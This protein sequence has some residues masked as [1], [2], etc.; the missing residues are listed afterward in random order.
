MPTLARP[1]CSALFS[2]V[3]ALF[4]GSLTAIAVLVTSVD[5]ARADPGV[6]YVDTDAP[7]PTH[8]GLSWTTAFTSV[9]DALGAATYDDQIW[10]AEGVYFPDE[11][12]GQTN[13]DRVSTFT[14]RPGVALCGGF[15]GGEVSLTE[16]DWTVNVTVLSGDIDGDD[17]TDDQGVVTDTANIKNNNAY[18]VVTGVA[19][20][21]TA[22]LDGF[23]ITAGSADGHPADKLGGGILNDN[24]SSPTLTNL[25]FSGNR[26]FSAGGGIYCGD[27]SSPTLSNAS[28]TSNSAT[29]SGGGMYNSSYSSPR[30]TNVT[31]EGNS[32]AT[33][34]ESGAGM[35]N[36]YYSSP[37]LINVV[38]KGN[39]TSPA[40]AAA[41]MSNRYGSSPMLA[42][43][44]FSGNRGGTVGAMENKLSSNPTLVNCVLWGNEGSDR[45]TIRNSGGSSPTISYSDV[46]G[47]GG[48]DNW[49]AAPWAPTAGTTSTPTRCSSIPSPG[50]PRPRPQATTACGPAPRPST[51][52]TISPSP[53]PPTSTA[54]HASRT[55]TGTA[56]KWWICGR[57]RQG[58]PSAASRCGAANALRSPSGQG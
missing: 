58:S 19:L 16:R 48:S 53:S 55:A 38:F 11:G 35:V 3:S 32:S 8:N 21:E 18:H 43:V 10:V 12:A 47:S 28:L 27:H 45:P 13:D 2:V 6:I 31:F 24:H 23:T 54:S 14:L 57:M 7:G 4:L 29:D 52:G 22:R 25:V 33:V 40:G 5:T 41:A 30:L 44:T 42:S 17:D 1:T 49:D 15:A 39:W 9:Q 51:Q 37:S 50:A 36:N 20:T 34:G 56:A 26:A 46:Q